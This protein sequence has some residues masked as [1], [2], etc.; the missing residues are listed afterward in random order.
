MANTKEKRDIL[1]L[2]DGTPTQVTFDYDVS[3]AK[4]IEV[5]SKWSDTGKAIKFILNVNGDKVIFA[6]E[7]L[8]AKL[9]DFQ[10]GESAVISFVEKRWIVNQG[11]DTSNSNANVQKK[12]VETE[13]MV[14]LRGMYE[15]ISQMHAKTMGVTPPV[16]E[17]EKL[18]T[19]DDDLGF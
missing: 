19:D 2:T 7:A 5:D 6:S 12:L 11:G 13:T 14:L 3:S 17:A 16:L 18:P 9:K 4:S 1:N 10:K 8:Y 15:M